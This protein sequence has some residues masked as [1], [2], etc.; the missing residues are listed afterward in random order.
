VFAT[1]GFMRSVHF[2]A[3]MLAVLCS[4][5]VIGST[6]LAFSQNSQVIPLTS[7]SCTP[8]SGSSETKLAC[9]WQNSS[10]TCSTN[11]TGYYSTDWS[12]N[13]AAV[14][15]TKQ[16]GHCPNCNQ[17]IITYSCAGDMTMNAACNEQLSPADVEITLTLPGC[18]CCE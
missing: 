15:T 1:E 4:F 8:A 12:C 2:V 18:D 10:Y 5:F 14:T 17:L 13:G 9:H 11:A 7:S 3:F 6:R 16:T